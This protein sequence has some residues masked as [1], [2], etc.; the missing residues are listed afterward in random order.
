MSWAGEWAEGA[1]SWRLVS[2]VWL[3]KA[4]EFGM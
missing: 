3:D 2:T 4:M 1:G